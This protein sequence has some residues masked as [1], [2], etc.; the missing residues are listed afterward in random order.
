MK[1]YIDKK[2]FYILIG[3]VIAYNVV[4]VLRNVLLKLSEVA[5]YN[6]ASW[7]RIILDPVIGNS[8]VIPPIVIIILII[9]K[10]MINKNYKWKY[11]IGIHF[12]FSFI[13]TFI[14][15]IFSYTYRAVVDKRGWD[16]FDTKDF[17][18]ELITYSN[19]HFLGYVGFVSIIYS[20][21][22]IEKTAK[23][24]L[25]RTQ[26]SEQL[27]QVKMEAL[28]S[29]LNPHFLFNTLNSISALIK[30]DQKKAQDMIAYLGD[31][32]REVLI[33]KDVNLIPLHK[34]ISILNKYIDIMKIRFSDHLTIDIL[35]EDGIKE[36]LVP[37]MIIQPIIE[38]SF[39]H[40]YSY[41]TTDLK[42]KLQITKKEEELIINITNNG[43]ALDHH[44]SSQGLGIKNIKERLLTLYN[45]NYD[46]VFRS[47]QNDVG[48]ETIIKIPIENT[49]QLITS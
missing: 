41:D 49:E 7:K 39:K 27:L 31:L 43:E 33:L 46:F 24:E 47:S 32:L 35:I 20:Y 42:V 21:F 29:Q 40:G 16:I 1:K 13:Y 15:Y 28:K 25:R 37:N 45:N 30:E 44:Q 36:V 22:Y 14:L 34:E 5:I 11:I 9:T 4:Y 18:I 23:T 19:L 26:L 10:M 2:L 8:I 12:F 17:F 6:N 38:N 3:Y 48:V